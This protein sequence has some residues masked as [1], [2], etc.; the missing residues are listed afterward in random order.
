[1]NLRKAIVGSAMLLS[2]AASTASAQV[3]A[4]GPVNGLGTFQDL[5]T[6]RTWLRLDNW[7]NQTPTFMVGAASTAGFTLA[8]FADVQQL[9]ASLPLAGGQWPTYMGIMGGA[10]NRGLI[11]GMYDD[12]NGPA[13]SGWAWSYSTDVSWQSSTGPD[14]NSIPNSGTRFTDLNVW[15]YQTTSTVPEPASLLLLGSGVL[16]IAALARK[17]KA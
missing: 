5:G 13:S 9:E 11:W 7:F 1:M 6:S 15:A 10:P 17:R 2:V 16:A 3:V 8:N 12:G 4:S 14:W